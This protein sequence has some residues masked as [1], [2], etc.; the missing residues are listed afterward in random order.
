MAQGYTQEQAT[1]LTIQAQ[2]QAAQQSQSQSSQPAATTSTYGYGASSSNANFI[3]NQEP[4]SG[5]AERPKRALPGPKDEEGQQIQ[6]KLKRGEK[7]ETVLRKAAGKL[8][9][10][11]S[12]LEWDPSE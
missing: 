7:R 3:A 11:R 1:S 9:E 6:G 5:K 10:D 4:S 2:Q 8:W 12:L